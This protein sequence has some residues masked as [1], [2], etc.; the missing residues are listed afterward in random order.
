M[1]TGNRI[2]EHDHSIRR[3][4]V[5]SCFKY[6]LEISFTLSIN[7]SPQSQWEAAMAEHFLTDSA[8][9]LETSKLPPVVGGL[10]V[11]VFSLWQIWKMM[12][13]G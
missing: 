5:S 2:V 8:A 12:T 7:R 4:F 1:A 13:K 11:I 6:D 3:R 9:W 10:C